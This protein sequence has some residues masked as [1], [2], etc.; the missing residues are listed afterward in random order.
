SVL[1]E[2]VIVVLVKLLLDFSYYFFDHMKFTAINLTY[3]VINPKRKIKD[4]PDNRHKKHKQQI[5]QGLA[6]RPSIKNN[7]D[8]YHNHE[9]QIEQLSN[10]QPF[11]L[12]E[13][14]SHV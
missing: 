10:N 9:Q 2:I 6:H 7:S 12:F 13:K 1:F 4:N 5:G 3:S 8:T 11:G 14:C